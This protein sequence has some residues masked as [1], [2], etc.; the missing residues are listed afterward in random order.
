MSFYPASAADATL[1][2]TVDNPAGCWSV[3]SGSAGSGGDADAGAGGR[4]PAAAALACGGAVMVAVRVEDLIWPVGDGGQDDRSGL[5]VA[6]T[7]KIRSGD[8]VVWLK[9]VAVTP[10]VVRRDGRVQADG[11]PCD[12]VGLGV[13]EEQLDASTGCPDAI[14]QAA[15]SVSL[16]GT[17]VKAAARR[18]MS[19]PA[20]IRAV[21][22]MTAMPDADYQ[23][24]MTTLFGDLVHVPWKRRFTIP[25]PTVLSTWRAAIGPEPLKLLQDKVFAAVDAE[26][27]EHDY[28]AV[29]I[30]GGLQVGSIDGCLTRTPDTDA[31][32]TAFG[33]TG[34]TDDSAPYPQLRHLHVS[35][36][37]TRAGLAVVAGPAGTDKAEAEQALLDRALIEYPFVF[38]RDRC[39]VMDRNFPGVARI[40]RILATGTHVLIRLKSDVTVTR[41][42]DFFPDGSYLATLSGGGEQ[43]TLR[44]IEYLVQ[45]AG[46]QAPDM[47]CLITDLTDHQ[48]HPAHLLAAAYRWRWDGSETALREA[49]SLIRGAGPSTGAILRSTTPELIAQ[50]HAAWMC[51]TELVHALTRAAARAATPISKGRHAGQNIQPRQISFTTARRTAIT[52]IR[53]TALATTG[54]P[55]AG[56]AAYQ[57]ALTTIGKARVQTDRNRHRD[58]K[59]KT[60]QP[61]PNAPRDI[62]TV[63]APAQLHLC[64]VKPQAA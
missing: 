34:T 20:A 21:L 57:T 15:A 32:R 56:S 63:T 40:K 17:K 58:R 48:V 42:S 1:I 2:R 31:N 51:V 37:S 18:V 3:G 43:V 24:I 45:V 35:D 10:A 36:A 49:K 8:D 33:S 52:T 19:V 28:T 50:E 25:S 12:H 27:R 4:G 55:G 29:D 7:E 39:W 6:G 11:R 9:V 54:L 5:V 41:I 14:G 53:R 62:S 46:Q 47:F 23:E 38:T 30:G 44:V 64:G 26:H 59:V 60:R 61:F 16:K 13:L 22:L